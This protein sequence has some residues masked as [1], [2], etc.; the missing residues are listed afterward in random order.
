MEKTW[1]I[2]GWKIHG[3][4]NG[5]IMEKP[6]KTQ[7]KI[8]GKS[9]DNK[10]RN[11]CFRGTPWGPHGDP[12]AP[13][14]NHGFPWEPMGAHGSPWVPMGPHGDPMEYHGSISFFPFW[15]SM[16]FHGFPMEFP[17]AFPWF[18]HSIFHGFSMDWCSMNFPWITNV[19]V[20]VSGTPPGVRKQSRHRQN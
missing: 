8:H 19:S 17:M 15:L 6:C 14:R 5:K 7:W 9:M 16:D 10:K 13:M 3:K 11:T 1:E 2:H 20:V 18:F 4:L 12:W